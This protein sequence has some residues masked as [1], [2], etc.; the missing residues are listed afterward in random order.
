MSLKI[1][2]RLLFNTSIN[3]TAGNQPQ[4]FRLPILL[5][6]PFKR[7]KRF[8][9][10]KLSAS[11]FVKFS[12]LKNFWFSAKTSQLRW[13]RPFEQMISFDTHSTANLQPS[14]ILKKNQGFFVRNP[15]GFQK[16]NFRSTYLRNLTLS[17]TFYVKFDAIWGSQIFKFRIWEFCL[18]NWQVRFECFERMIFLPYYKY[19]G[20]QKIDYLDSWIRFTLI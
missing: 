16:L 11:S 18:D 2:I 20:K 3:K 13:K 17:I 7:M 9:S 6:M 8:F 5:K 1:V 4:I 14:P 19:D 10:K 15:A 12:N